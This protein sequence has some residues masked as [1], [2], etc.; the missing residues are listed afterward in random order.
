MGGIKLRKKFITSKT[1]I[2]SS[3][4]LSSDLM[5]TKTDNE[6]IEFIMICSN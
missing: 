1:Y 2:N 6:W 4:L 3:F 5:Q